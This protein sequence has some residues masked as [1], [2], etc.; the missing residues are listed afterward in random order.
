MLNS[1]FGG[2]ADFSRKEQVLESEDNDSSPVIYYL[3]AE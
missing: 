3:L 1:V 2:A